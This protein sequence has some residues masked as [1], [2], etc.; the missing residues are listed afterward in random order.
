MAFRVEQTARAKRDLDSIFRRLVAEGVCDG[1]MRW[2]EQLEAA[3]ESLSEMPLCCA[4]APE[5][6]TFPFEVRHLLYGRRQHVY[7]ILFTINGNTVIVLH[8]R[9]GTA[10][11]HQ[12]V[13]AIIP[14]KRQ[15]PTSGDL[16]SRQ[17]ALRRA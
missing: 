8:I 12:G 1:G 17:R 13:T 5:N 6:A 3:I 11:R 10:T 16:L 4:L 15:D 2:A 9:H 14:V 7:R